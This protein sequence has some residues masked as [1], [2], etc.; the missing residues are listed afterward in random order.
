[1]SSS[2]KS[3]FDIPVAFAVLPFWLIAI[4]KN[5]ISYFPFFGWAVALGGTIFVKRSDHSKALKSLNEGQ[6][7]LKERPRSVLLFPEGTRSDDG[8]IRPFKKGGLILAIQ[9]GYLHNHFP[10]RGRSAFNLTHA[11]RLLQSSLP[12]YIVMTNERECLLPVGRR[13][14]AFA[15]EPKTVLPTHSRRCRVFLWP[16]VVHA[17]FAVGR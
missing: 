5:I 4:A 17:T 6:K 12:L 10:N 1:M 3:I 2:P 14:H 15:E 9:V 16:F 13:M 11:R 7:S 8:V